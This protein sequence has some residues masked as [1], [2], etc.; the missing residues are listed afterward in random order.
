MPNIATLRKAKKQQLLKL[1]G[2]EFVNPLLNLLHQSKYEKYAD[3]IHSISLM[4]FY[5][6]YWSPEQQQIYTS[7]CKKNRNAVLTIDATGGI[8]TRTTKSDPHV[9]LYQCM[10]VTNEGSVPVFQM[11]SADQRS[12]IIAHFLRVILTKNVPSIIVRDF[13]RALINAVAKVF[14]KCYDPR[15]YLQKC[16]NTIVQ[17][18]SAVPVACIK[19]DVGHFIAMVSRWKCFDK[20]IIAAR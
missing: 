4:K 5:C 16:Y 19:L 3:C 2:L 1:H 15:D 18:S 6:I 20:K 10:L 14:G 13:G 8:A 17:S 11:V 12:L 9:F 7:R